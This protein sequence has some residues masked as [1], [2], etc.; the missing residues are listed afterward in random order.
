M[1]LNFL[2]E[3]GVDGEFVEQLVTF[4]TAYEHG[5]YI[6]FLEHLKDFVNAK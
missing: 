5:R 3:R 2:E 1:L 4:A 6:N